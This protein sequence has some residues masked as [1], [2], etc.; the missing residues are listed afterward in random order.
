MA[1]AGSE[2]CAE[3]SSRTNR[4]ESAGRR[5]YPVALYSRALFTRVVTAQLILALGCGGKTTEPR[6][7]D[8]GTSG[9]GEA[10]GGSATGGTGGSAGSIVLG[11]TN[12][13]GGSG[14]A[15]G[16]PPLG[17]GLD[18]LRTERTAP[19][20]CSFAFP[21][22][23]ADYVVIFGNVNVEYVSGSGEKELLLFVPSAE[24]RDGWS[25]GEDHS[26]IVLCGAA[27]D[28]LTRDADAWLLVHLGCS[29]PLPPP[30]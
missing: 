28:R 11:G 29:R 16:T 22:T 13:V 24:C 20:S 19:N 17:C 3:N 10:Q 1:R 27:C 2:R 26:Q 12:S 9:A 5:S 6:T 23:P 21:E 4:A 25:Y 14:G 15:G 18:P 8:S 7:R 30:D